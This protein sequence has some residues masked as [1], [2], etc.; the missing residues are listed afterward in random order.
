MIAVV[1]FRLLGPD[2]LD[3]ND[4]AKQAL[5]VLDVWDEGRWILPME[6]GTEPA[7]KPPLFTW[8]AVASCAAFGRPTELACRLPSAAAALVVAWLVFAMGRERWG[9]R[10]GVAAAWILATSHTAARLAIH[11]RPDMVLTVLTTT[12]LFALHRLELGRER[13]MV[14]LFWTAASLSILTKGPPGL[15]VIAAAIGGLSVAREWR[16][17]IR[18][19]LV[20]RWMLVLLVP[21]AWFLLAVAAGG[22]EYLKGT[23]LSQTLERVLAS[24]SRAGKG[25]PPG[26]LLAL[27]AAR[28]APW[29]IV[30]VV[31]AAAAIVKKDPVR[32]RDNG[33]VAAWLFGG[34]AVFSLSRG[35]REDY[36]LPLLPAASLFVASSLEGSRGRVVGS[37]WKVIVLGLAAGALGTGAAAAFGLLWKDSSGR[38]AGAALL[39]SSFL[40]SAAAWSCWRKRTGEG[41]GLSSPFFMAAGGMLVLM[42]GYYLFL[43]PDARSTKG[44]DLRE[45]AAMVNSSRKPEDEVRLFGNLANGIRFLTRTNVQASS[46]DEIRAL[47][48]APK[49]GGNLLVL[50]DRGCVDELQSS[51]PGVLAMVLS[52][53]HGEGELALLEALRPPG[54]GRSGDGGQEP[55]KSP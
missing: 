33:L 3:T 25:Q 6:R 9:A 12:A 28:F 40:F 15:L 27:F 45:F 32:R 48:E 52:H 22:S 43:S 44:S 50:T 42:A 2:D 54:P 38:Y 19:R 29:S 41:P 47:L 55:P 17:L 35:Q 53:R 31:A 49:R 14:G 21:L 26:R 5:Y 8:L 20:S 36:L 13:G 37:V 24:G 51:L 39:A 1:A 18:E 46:L 34:L 30:A 4:Q 11:V 23:V 7:T 10:A 16:R